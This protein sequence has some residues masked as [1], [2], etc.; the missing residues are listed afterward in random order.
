MKHLFKSLFLLTLLCFFYLPALS[1]GDNTQ[2]E[3]VIK[4][5]LIENN[6]MVV[7]TVDGLCCRNCGIG[8]G[9]KVCKLNFIDTEKLPKGVKIDR[10]NGLLSIA[11][12]EN[13]EVDY[14]AIYTAIR[15]AG[16]KPK[17]LFKKDS[18]NKINKSDIVKK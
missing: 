3:N 9:K 15:K 17:A 2:K 4:S 11:L 18:D 14:E 6:N 16:Y 10:I 1:G 12:K 5:L 13:E 8:I 7:I